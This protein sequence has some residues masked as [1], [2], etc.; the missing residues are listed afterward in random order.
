MKRKF[1]VT[2]KCIWCGNSEPLVSFK[3]KPHILPDSAGGNELGNDICDCCN[4]FFGSKKSYNQPSPDLIFKEIFNLE[5]FFNGSP[6]IT[7]GEKY[8]SELFPLID[9]ELHIKHNILENSLYAD[10]LKSAFYEIFLQKYHAFTHNGHDNRF[11]G[12]RCLARYNANVCGLKVYYVH[13]HMWF[14]KCNMNQTQIY[15]N[16]FHLKELERTG[17]YSFDYLGYTFFLEIFKNVADENRDTYFNSYRTKNAIMRPEI[18]EFNYIR[19]LYD[20]FNYLQVDKIII[21]RS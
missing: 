5:R 21:D 19:Q 16:D 11:D 9:G 8:R 4:S 17:F 18:V 3:N 12:V 2:G 1:K 13:T 14:R 20:I 7:N 15:F 6:S 10:S